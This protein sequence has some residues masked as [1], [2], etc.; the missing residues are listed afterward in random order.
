MKKKTFYP[1]LAVFFTLVISSYY[2][3]PKSSHKEPATLK[4]ENEYHYTYIKTIYDAPYKC[5]SFSR[6][7]KAGKITLFI[8]STHWCAPCIDLKNRI[9]EALKSNIIDP[10][11]VDVYNY[12]VSRSSA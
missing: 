12:M 11:Q 5:Y 1:F 9:D 4:S 2:T 6:I 8:V 10:K 3:S 7:A